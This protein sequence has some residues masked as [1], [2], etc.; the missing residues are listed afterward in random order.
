[1]TDTTPKTTYGSYSTAIIKASMTNRKR[2]NPA[3]LEELA[4]SIKSKGVIQPILLRPSVFDETAP[5]IC[6]EIV[7]GERRFRASI[8]A[9]LDSIPA[10]VRDLSDA[11]AAEMQVVENL[12]R[13]DVHPL[14]EAEGYEQLMLKHGYKADDLAVKVGKSR[15]YIYGRLKYCALTLDVRDKFFDDEISAS[16]ALLL[17]RI[18]VPKL[19]NQ[20]AAEIT[21]PSQFPPYSSEPMSYRRAVKHLQDRFMLS[22][23]TAPFSITDSKLLPAAGSCEKC[24]KRTGNQPEIFND[25]DANVCTDPDCFTEKRTAADW[26]KVEMARKKGIPV[27]EGDEAEAA[28]DE[29][30]YAHGTEVDA[31]CQTWIFERIKPEHEHKSIEDLLD[32]KALPKATSVLILKNGQ[33]KTTFDKTAIQEALE[34]AGLAYTIDEHTARMQEKL[35]SPQGQAKAAEEDTR[36]AQ[37]DAAI[38][39]AEDETTFRIELYKQLRLKGFAGFSLESLRTFVKMVL[40]TV[41]NL[42]R[43]LKELY[44]FDAQNKEELFSHIDIA[45]LEQVQLLLVDVLV[46]GE[47]TVGHWNI[48]EVGGDDDEFNAIIKMAEYEGIEPDAVRRT[49]THPNE[50][51]QIEEIKPEEST[52]VAQETTAHRVK[53]RKATRIARPK[54][55]NTPPAENA[56]AWPFTTPGETTET[57]GAE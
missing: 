31:K 14:E 55:V 22:L 7:A 45:S 16:V 2:F 13:E 53:A 49:I 9:E 15:S 8:I 41:G 19:Q 21:N 1:M 40:N 5:N 47:L 37:R 43:E 44:T 46:G 38:Q 51:A 48:D 57:L 27:L 29:T 24:P 42:P 52:E 25:I 35:A 28:D 11:D 17:A 36:Q 39:Q 34:K 54:I 10:I 23:D 12:Q 26:K 33:V 3:K 18:P 20:A 50:A 30:N 4:A 6:Y 32:D 56:Y